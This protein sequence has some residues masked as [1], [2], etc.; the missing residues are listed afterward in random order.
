MKTFVI[1]V[2]IWENIY[3]KNWAK[4]RSEAHMSQPVSLEMWAA[5][6][7]KIKLYSWG[8]LMGSQAEVNS[9]NV[10]IR[11]FN[12]YKTEQLCETQMWIFVRKSGLSTFSE[13]ALIKGAPALGD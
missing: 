10:S 9:I 6:D 13:V 1:Y 2:A 3:T 7:R 12:K 8:E 5:I 11:I 4:F